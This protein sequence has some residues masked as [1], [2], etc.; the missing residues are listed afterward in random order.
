MVQQNS[1]FVQ[2][3]KQVFIGSIGKKMWTF[4]MKSE[5]VQEK[6]DQEKRV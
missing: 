3:H 5:E 4:V 6:C 1:K 2:S